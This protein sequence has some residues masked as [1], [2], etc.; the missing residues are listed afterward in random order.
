MKR[1]S[2]TT[3]PWADRR[4]DRSSPAKTWRFNLDFAAAFGG[5][6]RWLDIGV[7]PGTS[8]GAFSILVPRQEVT[9]TPAAVFSAAA[10]WS[11]VSAKPAGFADDVDNDSGGTVTSVTAGTG[12]SGGTITTAGTLA[13]SFGGS[14]AAAA[15]ARSDHNHDGTYAGTAHNHLGESWAGAPATG[16]EVSTS[17]A[18]GIRGLIT[19]GTGVTR[20]VWGESASTNG[21]GVFGLATATTG[22]NWGV[23]GTSMS[24]SGVGVAGIVGAS[25]TSGVG[26]FGQSNSTTAGTG[27]FGRGASYGIHGSTMNGTAV[28]G[29]AEGTTGANYAV[30]GRTDS[31]TVERSLAGPPIR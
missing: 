20:A 31:T 23:Y 26:V 6:K 30:Y 5:S 24:T 4:S 19:G 18:T 10:P 15:A 14:G 25:A 21:Q 16:L 12:L 3:R 2:S 22:L 28:F 13:V 17:G 7:R 1:F 29:F 9:P 11:G 27:V 8:A